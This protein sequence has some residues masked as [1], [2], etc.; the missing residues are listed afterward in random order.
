MRRQASG[1]WALGLHALLMLAAASCVP[2]PQ[3]GQPVSYARSNRGW[4]IHGVALPNR[5]AGYVR[6]RPGDATRYGVPALTGMVQR[7]AATVDEARPGGFPLRVGDLSSPAGG[8]HYRHGSHRTG[9]DVDFI[10]YATDLAGTP[11][12]GRGWVA[13]DRFGIGVEPAE[14]GGA[15]VRFD[16]A[17]NWALVRAMLVDEAD[18]QWIFVS[19]GLKAR[20]LRYAA[21]HESDPE[22]LRRAAWVVHQPSHGNP[23]ADHFH[24]RIACGAEQVALGCVDRGPV[25]P[26]FHD[27]TQKLD[28][29]PRPLT[30]EEAVALI[31]RPLN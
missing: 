24:V 15:T 21:V 26:W 9:R 12:R 30:D 14:Y 5:G 7:I 10:F 11:V 6:A 31:T 16:D 1:G 18:V 22:V 27:R 20:L 25:W 13:Y 28:E 4:L 19:R 8:R 17:R 2:A 23:H 3:P 29:P